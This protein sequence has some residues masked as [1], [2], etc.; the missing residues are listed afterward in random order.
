M[1][2]LSTVGS[3][4]DGCWGIMFIAL[5]GWRLIPQ[6]D[7]QGLAQELYRISKGYLSEVKRPGKF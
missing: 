1:F 3:A 5:V 4:I 2:D 7:G 6:R